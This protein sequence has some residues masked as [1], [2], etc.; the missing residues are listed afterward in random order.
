MPPKTPAHI[1]KKIE[2]CR[3]T[4][5]Q[6]L[7]LS[8]DFRDIR[9]INIPPEVFS[10]NHLQTLILRG[11]AIQI[12]PE[13][14]KQLTQLKRLD[15]RG[16]PLNQVADVGG[17]IVHYADFKRLKIPPHNILGLKLTLFSH[18]A[19]E[20]LADCPNLT[21]L[22]ISNHR[23]TQIPAWLAHFPQ[24]TE[25]NLSNNKLQELTGLETL[26]NLS[27][28]FLRSN[29]LSSVSG[30]ATLMNLS[31]L[32]LSRNKL[33]SVSGLATLVNISSLDLSFNQLN[34]ISELETLIN[35]SILD[36]SDNTLNNISKLE[37]LK[38][39]SNLNLSRNRLNNINGIEVLVNLS[40]V[41]L[42]WN[43]L[44]NIY[45]VEALIN[46]TSLNL[47]V[48]QLNHIN[49]LETLVNLSFLDLSSNQLSNINEIE[50]LIN[51][52]SLSLSGNKLSDISKLKTLK[53]LS[54]LDLS[55]N[56]LNN[57]DGLEILINLSSLK[58]G[59][60]KLNYINKL[61]ALVNLSSLNL[62]FNQLTSVS[63]LETLV[64]LTSLNLRGN[65]L[66]SVSG[67]ER[68][69]NLSFLDLSYNQ[70]SRVSG[71]ERLV[72]LS[73]LSLSYNQLS[74]VSGLEVLVNLSYLDLRNN[75]LSSVSGLETLIHLERLYLADNP[76]LEKLED[77]LFNLHKLERLGIFEWD[78]KETAIN[79][80]P[81][82]Q[83]KPEELYGEVN[84]F[85]VRNYLRQLA[86]GEI[87]HLYEA[88]VLIIGEGGAG[89][90][91]LANKIKNKNYQLPAEGIASTEGIE[92]FSWQFPFDAQHQYQVNIWDFGGQEIY[93]ATHQFFLSKRALYLLVADNR[94]EDTDFYY[95][96]NVVDTL[97][98]SSPLFL[99][100]NEK[101]DRPREINEAALREQFQNFKESYATNL[102]TN[103]K[104]FSRF[105]EDLQ[106]RLKQLPHIGMPL[107]KTWLKVRNE[108][109][110][111]AKQKNSL[112]LEKYL[113][114]CEQHGFK[115]DE[116]KLQLSETLH[117]L[118]TILHFQ[119][120]A[121]LE[122]TL[123]L[124]P[125]WATQAVYHVLDNK[126]VQSNY[127]KF[128]KANLK[129]IWKEKQYDWMHGELL[130]LMLNFKL[131]YKLNYCEETYIAPQLLREQK[132]N[133]TLETENQVTIFYKNYKFMPKGMLSRL[134]V[135]FH[136]D[137][138]TNIAEKQTLVWRS[139]V[140]LERNNTRAEIIENYGA[141]EIKIC[142][143]GQDRRDLMTEIM[144]KLNEIHDSYYNLQYEIELPCNCKEPY[145]FNYKTL[146]EFANDRA[147]IQCQKR[148]CRQMVDA[149]DLL[150]GILNVTTDKDG[151]VRF[152]NIHIGHAENV[153]L[154]QAGRDIHK[155]NRSINLSGN[156]KVGVA[157]TGDNATI[158]YTETHNTLNQGIQTDL[159]NLKELFLNLELGEH[160]EKVEKL[161]I[162]A[163][164]ETQ[165]EKP[166]KEEIGSAL[167][168]VLKLVNKTGKLTTAVKD[169]LI[170][171]AK[172]VGE[173]LGEH[174]E[175]LLEFFN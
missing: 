17:L 126:T 118:G 24:L 121:L 21:L 33:S 66:N 48:N 9:L 25:L 154:D 101:G 19:P 87:V 72:N 132:P 70:L 29:Q 100:K 140:V 120:D 78:K 113:E 169:K 175:N 88:K 13:Q 15:L 22:E 170:P 23:L 124:N 130:Q 50:T 111:L 82:E 49:G 93:H 136:K 65:Q 105:L 35:I 45:G 128:T 117:D 148:G 4:Q 164:E 115:N 20:G 142:I 110:H 47:R 133:Y 89:K 69:V 80:P 158:N 44:N 122:K 54:F 144:C 108:L 155:E 161:L 57:I 53:N 173:W 156:S 5:A 68:L 109:E 151:N 172:T 55:S 12:V 107:P 145:Y 76:A 157:S 166:D 98:A 60:N 119:Q 92:V 73:I 168:R 11:N 114:I 10:L 63:E 112:S 90:T 174:G 52:N 160:R 83:L 131:C 123:F 147:A 167:D 2:E 62:N 34:N 39:L 42:S 16:N 64:N 125:E 141:R 51:L 18:D 146:K 116:D 27:T 30:L 81:L 7:D 104:D 129:E 14:I 8:K 171:I 38:Q 94:K 36:L 150:E 95:W 96:L 71:L 152:G 91:T 67:L 159:R 143:A 97:S 59:K 139:G 6:E 103:S 163:E 86:A 74:S 85:R 79:Y 135:I 31:S 75:Q 134:I 162:D 138:A 61:S 149:R 40:F 56:Q 26:V 84:L 43:Q 165:K 37:M 28:L 58:L 1:L 99:L 153:T 106:H 3:S 41:D 127:G 102:K 77:Q 46:L 32:D 137:I